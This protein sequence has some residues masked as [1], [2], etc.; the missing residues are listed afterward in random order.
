[1]IAAVPRTVIG[2]SDL[3]AAVPDVRGLVQDVVPMRVVD[4]LHRRDPLHPERRILGP[5]HRSRP[6]VGFNDFAEDVR[7]LM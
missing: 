5:T 4:A 3:I 7:V 2:I 1:M 6:V